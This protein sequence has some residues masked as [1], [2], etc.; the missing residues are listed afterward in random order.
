MAD[1]TRLQ[2]RSFQT[3]SEDWSAETPCTL[4]N[5]NSSTAYFAMEGERYWD[6]AKFS[7][8]DIFNRPY[9]ALNLNVF[10]KVLIVAN[11]SFATSTKI[12]CN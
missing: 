7:Y 9:I 4:I 1:Y 5:N 2:L 6:G 3:S 10:F 8:K 12:I 11:Q